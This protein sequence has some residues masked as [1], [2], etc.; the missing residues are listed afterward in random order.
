[1]KTPGAVRNFGQPPPFINESRHRTS[2]GDFS[3]KQI[4]RCFNNF[5]ASIRQADSLLCIRLKAV[6]NA[7]QSIRLKRSASTGLMYL[8]SMVGSHIENSTLTDCR[9]S[10]SN[11]SD[12]W[13]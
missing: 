8:A 2:A 11:S 1:M 6:S 3:S 10:S 12:S 9:N 5:S 13:R 7:S 4:I